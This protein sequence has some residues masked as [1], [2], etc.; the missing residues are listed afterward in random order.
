[1]CSYKLSANCPILRIPATNFVILSAKRDKSVGNV[2]FGGIGEQETGF[3]EI[4]HFVE[5]YACIESITEAFS[6]RL[7]TNSSLNVPLKKRDNSSF[8]DPII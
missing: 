1:M 6:E 3:P 5:R 7:K 2:Q 8:L 4:G